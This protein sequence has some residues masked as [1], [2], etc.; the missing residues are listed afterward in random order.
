MILERGKDD[1][2][3]CY[4]AL[5]PNCP[6][7]ALQMVLERGKDD[8]VSQYSSQNLN[9]SPE[10]RIRWMM[11]TGKITKEDPNNSNHKIE[12]NE[13]PKD[14]SA[15]CNINID[16][17][18]YAE[19]ARKGFG[20]LIAVAVFSLVLFLGLSGITRREVA[21]QRKIFSALGLAVVILVGIMLVSAFQRLVLYESAYGFSQLRTYTHLFMFW[22]GLLLVAVM[23]LEIMHKERKFALAVVLTSL[24]FAA[25]LALLNVDGFI[26]RENVERAMQGQELD[27]AYLASL[28]TDSIP[29]LVG[30]FNDIKLSEEIHEQIGASLACM[31]AIK[32]VQDERE[33]QSFNYS[34]FNGQKMLAGIETKLIAYKI[35]DYEY[36]MFVTTPSGKKIDCWDYDMMD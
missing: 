3:S 34:Q 24:G 19:Y 6:P 20:E 7:E 18:T 36:Q 4:A 16:G 10:A 12:Y 29:A 15:F 2:V 5:N 22:L 17:Y 35:I 30:K 32:P 28:S 25:S 31:S 23:F 33:W 13:K 9:C 11:S 8:G 27:A 14:N 21:V 26:V 1:D